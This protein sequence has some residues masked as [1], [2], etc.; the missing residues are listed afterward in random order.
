[1]SDVVNWFLN[2]LLGEL[3][4]RVLFELDDVECCVWINVLV[5]RDVGGVCFGEFSEE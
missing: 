4:L 1:M 5:F 2:L 3:W